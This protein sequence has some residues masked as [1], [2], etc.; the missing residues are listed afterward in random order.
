ML[1]DPLCTDSVE[2]QTGQEESHIG[3]P[4]VVVRRAIARP[5]AKPAP[6]DAPEKMLSGIAP[7]NGVEGAVANAFPIRGGHLRQI[8][9]EARDDRGTDGIAA[10][11]AALEHFGPGMLQASQCDLGL[12]DVDGSGMTPSSDDDAPPSFA[13]GE[14]E[15]NVGH[16]SCAQE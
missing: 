6:R 2:S 14:H 4:R 8:V 9:A 5:G 10:V 13:F 3:Q 11:E 7:T 1:K 16:G 12:Q 15:W